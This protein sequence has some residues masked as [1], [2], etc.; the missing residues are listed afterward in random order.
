M[1]WLYLPK[2]EPTAGQKG[3]LCG[4]V[5]VPIES[6]VPTPYKKGIFIRNNYRKSSEAMPND[7]LIFHASLE[8]SSE[9]A[10]T[11]QTFTKSGN[12]IFETIQ[13][14]K[15]AFFD[16]NSYLKVPFESEL[17]GNTAKA[18]SLWM[19]STKNET[20][21]SQTWA[22]GVGYW[23]SNRAFGVGHATSSSYSNRIYATM[24]GGDCFP[25]SPLATSDFHHIV[26]QYDLSKT[27]LF[28]DGVK[29][30]EVGYS[31]ANTDT[32][33]PI[34]IGWNN[35]SGNHK[36]F[37]GYI[38]SVRIYNRALGENE[39]K[40]LSREWVGKKIFIPLSEIQSDR[41]SETLVGSKGILFSSLLSFDRKFKK[42]ENMPTDGL[43]FYSAL[44]S[45]SAASTGQSIDSSSNV[46]YIDY[47]GMPCAKF[48]GSYLNYNY[49]SDFPTGK[50]PSTMS[51][52]MNYSKDQR[53][54]PRIFSYG[55]NSNNKNRV[56]AFHSNNQ[57]FGSFSNGCSPLLGDSDVPRN[58]WNFILVTFDGSTFKL[59]IDAQLIG[60][61]SYS[62]INTTLAKINIGSA[63]SGANPFFGYL[64]TARIYNRV[65]NDSEIQTLYT[66]WEKPEPINRVFIPIMD[67][68]ETE[69]TIFEKI[70]T[71]VNENAG[72]AYTA[73]ASEFGSL[74]G[75]LKWNSGVLAPN[76]KIYAIPYNSSSVL[77]ID[78]ETKTTST[79][80][81]VSGSDKWNGG[82][83]APNGKVYGIPRNSETVLEI[84]PLTRTTN[85]F[86][87]VEISSSGVSYVGGVLAPNGKIYAI[88]FNSTSI[89]KIDPETLDVSTFGRVSGS[90]KWCGGVVAPNGKIYA[91]PYS[92]SSVL[93][94]D[95]ETD[96]VVLFGSLSGS[97]KWDGGV[98]AP[99]GKIY[100]IPR[101]SSKVLEIDPLTRSVST[102][103][104]ISSSG[105]KWS[106][107]VLAPNG[108]IYAIP[109]DSATILEI[110]PLTRSVST[111]GG[112][113]S[114]SSKW[115]GGVLS[116][117]GNIYSIPSSSATIMEISFDWSGN[118][119]SAEICTSSLLNKF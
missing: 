64:S 30:K 109:R 52:W 91:I 80:G 12:V 119:F 42:N 57:R 62:T 81:S 55:D 4:D 117:N 28:V 99:N 60:S 16:G 87:N 38:S 74:S 34:T 51:I 94:I 116:A 67:K 46:S 71:A 17:A 58:K 100:G 113:S 84:D 73:M 22:F 44:S 97:S 49:S 72:I 92:S 96:S 18:V 36:K 105:A 26:F 21:D 86:G 5:F 68:I 107:G 115:R 7:G 3:F 108:K 6:G 101:S 110:D 88:P 90:E 75:S 20:E 10:E 82:V 29:L 70:V 54:W 102:F 112:I 13:G 111:F 25:E 1:G 19:W 118:P 2:I 93:E 106:G 65:L 14:M 114:S 98:L 15:C 8:Q 79:F 77:E 95:P 24:Y 32:A 35:M 53:D 61:A 59:Y 9:M 78:P 69:P 85:R 50:S 40:I 104:S 66:E 37:T 27:E 45:Q 11:G 43:V 23:S 47:Q 76:G 103:G 41:V 33:Y 48:D 83:L 56:L 89:L 39:I 63:N 31:S